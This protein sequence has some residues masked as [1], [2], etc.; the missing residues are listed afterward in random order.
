MTL[1]AELEAAR[2]TLEGVL[3][4]IADAVKAL[5][6]N[7]KINR[8]DDNCFTVS[9]SDLGSN[10]TPGYHDFKSQYEA[11]AAEI[12]SGNVTTA[13]GRLKKIVSSGRVRPG[14]RFLHPTVVAHLKTLLG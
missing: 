5:P 9:A 13:A 8:I 4:R 2:A 3:S 7:P 1:S 12:K 11:V 10:W 14:G 6:D